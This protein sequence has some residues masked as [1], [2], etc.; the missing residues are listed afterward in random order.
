MHHVDVGGNA[1]FLKDDSAKE[2]ER[3]LS[4][5]FRHPT[6]LEE[7]RTVAQIKCVKTFSYSEIAKRAI[8]EDE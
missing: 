7:M 1:V 2:I 4:E 5:L 3:V 8:S 6:K